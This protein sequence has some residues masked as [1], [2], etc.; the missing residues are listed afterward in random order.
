VFLRDFV[1]VK[2]AADPVSARIAGGDWWLAN[3]VSAAGD[4]TESQLMR[5][6]PASFG[7]WI[8]RDV[9]VRIGRSTSSGSAT[10]VPLRWEDARRPQLFPVLDGN[11]EVV[12]LGPER[13][14]VVLSATYR[15]PFE[16]AGQLLDQAF[17]HRVAEST[18]RSFLTQLGRVMEADVAAEPPR[19]SPEP[20]AT[21]S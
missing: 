16:R 20:P 15:P 1:D 19:P 8:A 9:R 3:L 5:I 21:L 7:E 14:R 12:P 11:L 2:C 13:C 17:L 6:G 18:V 10:L 4:D